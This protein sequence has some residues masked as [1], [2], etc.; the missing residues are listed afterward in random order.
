MKTADLIKKI[1]KLPVIQILGNGYYNDIKILGAEGGLL[2]RKDISESK[3]W[4]VG[5]I[6]IRYRDVFEL[7]MQL[8][9]IKRMEGVKE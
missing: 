1:E 3:K 2:K 9:K 4:N 7:L 5:W 8:K 6:A